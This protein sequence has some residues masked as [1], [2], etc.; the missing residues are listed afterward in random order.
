MKPLVP[1]EAFLVLTGNIFPVAVLKDHLSFLESHKEYDNLGDKGR[2]SRDETGNVVWRPDQSLHEADYPVI[3]DQE[4]G[5]VVIWEHPAEK[6]YGLCIAGID[7][8]HRGLVMPVPEVQESAE[9]PSSGF[10]FFHPVQ[11]NRNKYPASTAN[12]PNRYYL[13]SST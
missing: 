10:E 4:E 2:F 8:E 7:P 6:E 3:P 9:I 5:C 1:S 13:M 12:R 11:L